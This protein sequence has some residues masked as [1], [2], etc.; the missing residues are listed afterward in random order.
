M[1]RSGTLRKSFGGDVGGNKRSTG[2]ESSEL[3][4]HRSLSSRKAAARIL[5]ELRP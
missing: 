4:L 1:P 2:G 5:L 3:S